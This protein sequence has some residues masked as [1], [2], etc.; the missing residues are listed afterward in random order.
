MLAELT[1]SPNDEKHFIHPLLLKAEL[2]GIHSQLDDLQAELKEYKDNF[3]NKKITL[4]DFV[5]AEMKELKNFQENW[6]KNNAVK[7]AEWPMELLPGDWDEQ[8]RLYEEK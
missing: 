2:D 7:P 5:E 1:Q 4:D 3:M 6:K 8:L